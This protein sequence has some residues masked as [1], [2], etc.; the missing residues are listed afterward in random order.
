MAKEN[1]CFSNASPTEPFADRQKP[2]HLGAFACPHRRKSVDPNRP[3]IPFYACDH[4]DFPPSL[5]GKWYGTFCPVYSLQTQADLDQFLK[6]SCLKMPPLT[7]TKDKKCYRVFAG[8]IINHPKGKEYDIQ[9]GGRF[10]TINE[11]LEHAH[12]VDGGL[13][14][15]WIAEE[16]TPAHIN[17]PLPTRECKTGPRAGGIIF[18]VHSFWMSKRV[19]KF[20]KFNF[21]V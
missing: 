2:R 15:V 4:P 16:N 21:S 3:D 19:N 12:S 8:G 17:E 6:G 11:A 1:G 10:E 18:S 14:N 5:L 20:E 9:M 13:G 7:S